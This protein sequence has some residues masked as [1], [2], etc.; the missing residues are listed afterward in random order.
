M[1]F[2]RFPCWLQ[3][4]SDLLG[5]IESTKTDAPSSQHQMIWKQQ[6]KSS[7][8]SLTRSTDV[9]S[10][11]SQSGA[12]ALQHLRSS[13]QS[14]TYRQVSWDYFQSVHVCMSDKLQL[15][16]T[17]LSGKFVQR[18]G[19]L[20]NFTLKSPFL[21]CFRSIMPSVWRTMISHGLACMRTQQ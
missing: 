1:P 15:S 4:R 11:R 13:C 10:L 12:A 6:H 21:V 14:C 18:L 2:L 8:H 3:T 5:P 16:L 9:P 19:A 20:K 17:M 7:L